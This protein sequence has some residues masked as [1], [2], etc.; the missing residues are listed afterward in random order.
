[1][2]QSFKDKSQILTCRIHDRGMVQAYAKSR[3][4][5]SALA[6]PSIKDDMMLVPPCGNK[7]S[8]VAI[9]LSKLKAQKIHVESERFLQVG[10]FQVHVAYLGLGGNP[11][12]L[13]DMVHK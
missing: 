8:L 4:W 10:H 11:V 13:I 1:L 12:V 5:G 9:Q 6:L 7:C 3:S 2:Q